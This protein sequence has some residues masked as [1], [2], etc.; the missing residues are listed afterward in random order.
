MLH[1]P[2]DPL[3]VLLV[4]PAFLFSLF[5]QFLVSSRFKKY[6]EIATSRSVNGHAAAEILRREGIYGVQIEPV[7]GQLGDHYDPSSNAIRLSDSVYRSASIT[8]VGVAA[9]EA[10]H[11][12]QYAEGYAP[13]KVR[14]AIIPLTRFGSTLATPLIFLGFF[15]GM[16]GLINLGILLFG[17]VVVFQLITLPVEFD[18]SR[19][20]LAALS[21]SGILN[22]T[23]LGGA[24]K[25]LDAAALTYV[26]ALAVSAAQL[27]RF[28]SLPNR[29][30]R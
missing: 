11:A 7:S 8:S 5:A 22:E 20:A 3:Y 16:T 28:I 6:S 10:G 23:E 24:K 26:A 18:A 30:R 4:L 15:L 25:V 29:R 12:A 1:Y 21:R 27:L 9:H 17:A 14:A 13:I 19:R 2:T